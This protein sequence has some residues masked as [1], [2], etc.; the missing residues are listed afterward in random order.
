MLEWIGWLATAISAGSYFCRQPDALRR[1]QA[2]AAIVWIGY[3]ITVGSR[4]V[5]A[6]NLIIA[7]VAAYSSLR[8]RQPETLTE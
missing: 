5:I 7:V 3:G 6:A 1:V 8:Q 4:P 2:A